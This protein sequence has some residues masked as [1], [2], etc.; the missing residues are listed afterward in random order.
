MASSRTDI[1]YADM[2]GSFLSSWD[3]GPVV[4]L[5]NREALIKWHANGGLFSIATGRNINNVTCFFDKDEIDLPMVLVN[6]ALIYDYK[7]DRILRS[8]SLPMTFYHELIEA[9]AT[10]EDCALALSDAYDFV[11]LYHNIEDPVKLDYERTPITIDEARKKQPLKAAL[12]TK[13]GMVPLFA[14][15]INRLPSAADVNVIA[16]SERFLEIVDSSV[17]KG[18]AISWVLKT[19]EFPGKKRLIILGDHENDIS[20]CKVA[21]IIAVPENGIEELKQY[22]DFLVRGHNEGAL[23]DVVNRILSENR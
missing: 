2:D 8:T 13:P 18:N 5:P 1:I 14:D 23:Y 21:N 3:L 20:M 15:I 9:F 4:P 6:G 7:Q 10:W 22:A 16:S 12:V 11:A 19:M 17:S